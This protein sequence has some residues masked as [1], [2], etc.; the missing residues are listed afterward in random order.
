MINFLC[1]AVPNNYSTDLPLPSSALTQKNW[2]EG[3]LDSSALP[4]DAPYQAIFTQYQ[5]RLA[6]GIG[7]DWLKDTQPDTLKIA[8]GALAALEMI[9]DAVRSGGA[10]SN[11][12]IANWASADQ[13]ALAW[14]ALYAVLSNAK[15]QQGGHFR[16]AA[17]LDNEEITQLKSAQQRD[18]IALNSALNVERKRQQ[19]QERHRLNPVWCHDATAAYAIGKDATQ[20]GRKCLLHLDGLLAPRADNHF[21]VYLPASIYST[22]R[23][24]QSVQGCAI[25]HA[26]NQTYMGIIESA[27]D[28]QRLGYKAVLISPPHVWQVP[29]HKPAWYYCYQN[30][31]L[32]MIDNPLGNKQDLAKMIA[33]LKERHIAVYA[34]VVLNHMA[35]CSTDTATNTTLAIQQANHIETAPGLAY[36]REQLRKKYGEDP[37]YYRDQRLFYGSTVNSLGPNK[38]TTDDQPYLVDKHFEPDR[39]KISNFQDLYQV[40]NCWLEGLPT[41]KPDEEVI[42]LQQAYLVAL[43]NMGIVGFR[44]DAAKHLKLAHLQQVFTPE[45]CHGMH[46]FGE[47][48]VSNQLE[49]D[50]FM[51]PYLTTLTTHGVYDFPLFSKLFQAFSYGGD[52]LS[53]MAR[54]SEEIP[55]SRSITFTVNHDIPNNDCF[56]HMLFSDPQDEMLALA[57]LL[58]CDGGVPLIYSDGKAL[59]SQH[60]ARWHEQWKHDGLAAMI[61]FHNLMHGL[62]TVFIHEASHQ[63]CLVFTRGKAGLGIINKAAEPQCVTIDTNYLLAGELMSLTPHGGDHP[64]IER[65]DKGWQIS[66][67]PR[68]FGFWANTD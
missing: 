16:L 49:Y 38:G 21:P 48:I 66:V 55:W 63:H 47:I 37:A 12:L 43:K 18:A 46:L 29:T 51:R 6:A 44:I 10:E 8:A 11:V 32:R 13:A 19:A 53:L 14:M 20:Q 31:D 3:K 28:L 50:L 67:P 34:D 62:P 45:I 27:D 41:L 68:S 30:E 22:S 26:F 39:N 33:V 17:Q 15:Q 40:Q 25:L 36:P 5:Q 57:W 24:G 4:Q 7:T 54:H 56:H 9:A 64:H 60:A 58:G 35:D 1:Q 42:A 59:P 61:R 52:L 65:A 23:I 2:A